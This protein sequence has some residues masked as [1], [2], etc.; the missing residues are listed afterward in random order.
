MDILKAFATNKKKEEEGVWVEGPD[1]AQFL[2]A[3]MGNKRAQKLADRLMRPHRSAQ[4]KGSL[5]DDV[6]VSVTRKV[7]AEAILLDWKGVKI[8]A[9]I[10][11]YTPELGL[12]LFE[13]I[14]D[15]VEF[16]SDYAQQMKQ[17]QDDEEVATE[18]N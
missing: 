2:I 8:D 10:T 16:I 3:R 17:Y 9:K 13:E 4:R 5:A 11:P 7:M 12:R 15:F 6:L 1:G 14:P 18:K